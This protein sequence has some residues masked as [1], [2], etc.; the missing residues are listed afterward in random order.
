MSVLITFWPEQTGALRDLWASTNHDTFC[1]PQ[2]HTFF[3][4]C[5]TATVR[6]NA[7]NIRHFAFP[8]YYIHCLMS[9]TSLIPST[10]VQEMLTKPL[11]QERIS[12]LRGW[13]I[14]SSPDESYLFGETVWVSV[15]LLWSEASRLREDE[16]LQH[17]DDLSGSVITTN[18][19]QCLSQCTSNTDSL[20]NWLKLK[21]AQFSF[22]SMSVTI[23]L[24]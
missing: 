7:L 6:I 9:T 18:H 13:N 21:P 12:K 16:I 14:N 24:C 19:S 17:K 15:L 8:F 4:V 10:A 11:N 3:F 23:V 2:H 20:V 1:L 22:L 5:L